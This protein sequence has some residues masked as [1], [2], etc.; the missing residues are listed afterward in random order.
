MPTYRLT[1]TNK[2]YEEWFCELNPFAKLIF[3]YLCDNCDIA[4]FIELNIKKIAFD[5][6]IS[7]KDV[8]GSIDELKTKLIFSTNRKYIFIKNFTQSQNNDP[9]NEKNKAH[10]SIIKRLKNML[11]EFDFQTITDF[12]TSPLQGGCKGDARG[13]EGGC[14]GDASPLQTSLKNQSDVIDTQRNTESATKKA[15]DETKNTEENKM[16][17]NFM[18][19]LNKNCPTV[20][21]MKIQ[22]TEEQY[23]IMR[24]NNVELLKEILLAMENYKPL[25]QKNTS[26]YLTFLNWK[27]RRTENTQQLEI[28]NLPKKYIE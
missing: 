5:C 18:A 25:L 24:A 15:K 3:L 23:T 10:L 16:F 6:T 26:V 20:S 14:K 11:H 8:E 22:P 2:W 17:K 4:G 13:I 9:L 28:Q 27:K 1:Y 19:W 7:K 21:K 12:F